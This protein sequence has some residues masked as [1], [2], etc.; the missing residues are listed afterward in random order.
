VAGSS[1]VRSAVNL[2]HTMKVN[3][4]KFVYEVNYE[5]LNMISRTKL[6][7]AVIDISNLLS[8]NNI[9]SVVFY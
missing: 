6:H 8:D 2:S 9:L 4:P 3:M 5:S 7:S 1:V